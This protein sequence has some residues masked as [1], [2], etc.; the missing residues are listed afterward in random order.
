MMR[1]RQSTWT[2]EVLGKKEGREVSIF[3]MKRESD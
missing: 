3:L 1:R 2:E